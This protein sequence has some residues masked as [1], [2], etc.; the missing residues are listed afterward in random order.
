MSLL[1][2]R[3]RLTRHTP[4]PTCSRPSGTDLGNEDRKY[5]TQNNQKKRQPQR[6]PAKSGFPE[7]APERPDPRPERHV[8][9]PPPGTV[10]RRPPGALTAGLCHLHTERSRKPPVAGIAEARLASVRQPVKLKAGGSF[11]EIAGSRSLQPVRVRPHAPSA[12]RL[13]RLHE[14]PKH[15]TQATI[16]WTHQKRRME[17]LE[18]LAR[19][20]G[21]A[22]GRS[23]SSPAPPVNSTTSASS[24]SDSH[25]ARGWRIVYLGHRHPDSQRRRCRTIVHPRR[26]R[27]QRSRPAR[28]RTPRQR[29]SATRPQ[30]P[31]LP[32]RRLRRK[33]PRRRRPAPA[34]RRPSPRSRAADPTRPNPSRSAGP[35]IALRAHAYTKRGNE[36]QPT[37]DRIRTG[38][39]TASSPEK[40]DLYLLRKRSKP[41]AALRANWP[42]STARAPI[43]ALRREG[44]PLL[45]VRLTAAA[46]NGARAY[47]RRSTWAGDAGYPLRRTVAP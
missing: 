16:T 15:P 3:N 44:T 32:R 42:C 45:A 46:V 7:R 10:I 23:Q 33:S 31:S 39:S 11:S 35:Q 6:P 40:E 14:R 17:L 21:G 36:R 5:G 43:F 1:T 4:R 24:P 18:G 27:R 2:H 20:W 30:H 9:S 47:A 12:R 28:L 19:G 8:R 41:D 37:R 13:A 25:C 29:A 34:Y 22:S 38:G 26:R